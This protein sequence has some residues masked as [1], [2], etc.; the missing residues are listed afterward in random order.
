MSASKGG[1]RR[2]G[3][4]VKPGVSRG[5][6]GGTATFVLPP[7]VTRE[8]LL[9]RG[10]D[11]RFRSLVNDLLT[12][13]TRMEIVREH[14]GRRMGISG[15]QYSVLVAIA[16]LQG[17]TGVSVGAVAQA[18]H[19]SSAFIAVETGK[20]ARLGLVLKQRNPH[21]RRGVLLG[22]ALPGRLKIDRAG[23]AIRAVND[24]FFGG[25]DP[26]SFRAL[27]AA[28]STLVEG[29]RTAMNYLGA[30]AGKPAA[31]LEAAG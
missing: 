10:T 12:I 29:S 27:C 8:T 14:L 2:G 16:H 1:R 18:L 9:E 7:T 19:V 26:S 31:A 15:P 13:A 28:A 6:G 11:R 5:K 17:D 3:P 23:A 30:V 21:D 20:L 24:L 4:S 22:L 25:L